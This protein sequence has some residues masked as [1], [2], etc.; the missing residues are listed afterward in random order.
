MWLIMAGPQLR[1]IKM[2]NRP[3]VNHSIDGIDLK[4]TV[5]RKF[6]YRK[7]EAQKHWVTWTRI[8]SGRGQVKESQTKGCLYF[9]NI[10]FH[11]N[12]RIA[13]PMRKMSHRE[14]EVRTPMAHPLQ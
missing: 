7:T 9:T 12:N 8:A 4:P 14:S 13:Q 3:C 10:A 2:W 5:S 11:S 1:I 6:F